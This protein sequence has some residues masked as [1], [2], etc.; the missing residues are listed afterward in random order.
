MI[1]RKFQE[2]AHQRLGLYRVVER[3]PGRRPAHLS[4]ARADNGFWWM[5]LGFQSFKD[6]KSNASYQ[7]NG[8]P[9]SSIFA[10]RLQVP[11]N[12][13][14]FE[15]SEAFSGVIQEMIEDGMTI[16]VDSFHLEGG[17]GVL[18]ILE[19]RPPVYKDEIAQSD[20]YD[21]LKEDFDYYQNLNKPISTKITKEAV[22]EFD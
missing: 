13:E 6:V 2:M 4:I 3:G 20:W 21:S 8:A 22:E 10:R 11:D 5:F 9:L 16:P 12:Y 17:R 1:L 19:C 7:K 15:V 18:C 14:E